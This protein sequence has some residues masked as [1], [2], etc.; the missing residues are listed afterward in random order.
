MKVERER[1]QWLEI[2]R[3][4]LVAL[5]SD[6]TLMSRLVL[7]GGN[8]LALAYG[9]NTRASLDLDFSIDGAF[10]EEDLIS[11][12]EK[13]EFRLRQ[14]MSRYDMEVMDVV[15]SEKPPV[16]SEEQNDFW[17]G[18]EITFKLVS[19]GTF[20]KHRSDTSALRR[21]AATVGPG[22]KRT[23]RIDISKHEFL[24]DRAYV[25]VLGYRIAVYS[26][27]MLVA[28]KLRAICQQMP[29]YRKLVRSHEG[30]GRSRDFYDIHAICTEYGVK[31]TVELATLARSSFEQKRVRWDALTCLREHR[32][33]HE[34]DYRSLT[35]TVSSKDLLK[36]FLFYF[37]W[38]SDFALEL[39]VLGNK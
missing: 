38:V 8:A 16:L 31:P 10:S 33:I 15:L 24:G 12:R 26:K 36:P 20:I 29:E 5:F 35:D 27:T 23:F 11:T 21:N 25:N 22:Q 39:H 14:T 9:L 6:D 7:K 17:G 4:V 1:N 18:Y 32:S 34:D 37:D 13:V 3:Y 2:K 30:R 28:E 19:K